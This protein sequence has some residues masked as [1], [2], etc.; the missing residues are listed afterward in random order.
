VI[1]PPPESLAGHERLPIFDAVESHWF[2]RGRQA[3]GPADQGGKSWSSSADDGW[4][5]AQV[6]HAPASDG[7]TSS[8]LPKRQPQANLVPG[9]A[10]ASAAAETPLHSGSAPG[11]SAEE[12]RDRFASF[13]RGRAAATGG[14]AYSGEGTTA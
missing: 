2:S 9:S 4:R 12:N 1:V 6:V 11:R 10:A 8:G 5:A 13:Q 7:T 14:T 3:I